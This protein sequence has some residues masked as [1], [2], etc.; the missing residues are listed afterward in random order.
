MR[1]LYR[2]TSWKSVTCSGDG[3][4]A[5][6]F[7]SFSW[8]NG[9]G[10]CDSMSSMMPSTSSSGDLPPAPAPAVLGCRLRQLSSVMVESV[11]MYEMSALGCCPKASG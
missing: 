5:L 11:I 6:S 8:L 4:S 1:M 10:T 3:S 2:S 7:I 9:C